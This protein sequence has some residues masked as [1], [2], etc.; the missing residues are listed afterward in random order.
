MSI[1]IDVPERLTDVPSWAVVAS[2][3]AFFLVVHMCRRRHEPFLAVLVLATTTF[4]IMYHMNKHL[5][6]SVAGSTMEQLDTY[7]SLVLINVTLLLWIQFTQFWHELVCQ[8]IIIAM[9]ATVYGATQAPPEE[10]VYYT[11]GGIVFVF[12]IIWHHYADAEALYEPHRTATWLAF[13]CMIAAFVTYAISAYSSF[14]LNAILWCHTAWH[15][16]AALTMTLLL[17]ARRHLHA[18]SDVNENLLLCHGFCE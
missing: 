5:G 10:W 16:L 8:L 3:A 9:A 17:Y 11:M 1:P 13:F 2:N 15:I 12:C 6:V 4:S 7:G 14:S 18:A